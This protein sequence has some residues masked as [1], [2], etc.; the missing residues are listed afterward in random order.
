MKALI[1]VAMIDKKIL[2]IRGEKVIIGADLA[3]LYE[4]ETNS[5]DRK[6]NNYAHD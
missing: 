1:P 2:L 6:L 4:V 5:R 3:E